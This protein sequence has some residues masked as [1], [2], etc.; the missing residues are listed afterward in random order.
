MSKTE[1]NHEHRQY[2]LKFVASLGVDIDADAFQ[3]MN[4]MRMVSHALKQLGEN[5][6]AATDL[7]MAQY[8]ILMHLLFAKNAL[9]RD[10]LNP[11][12]I[13]DRLGVTRNTISSLIRSL[14][15]KN[16]IQR[17]LDNNDRRKF[18]ISLT[19]TGAD[20]VTRY[21]EHHMHTVGSCFEIL[22][23]DERKQFSHY[24]HKLNSQ[25]EIAR[26]YIKETN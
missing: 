9:S 20:L 15:E 5:S 25:I 12:E 21:A 26:S 8:R 16:L 3:L 4:E 1:D 19:A 13:S 10:E 24:L 2:W 22:D 11:S 23:T 7:S 6:L 14:E 17:Q 18:N